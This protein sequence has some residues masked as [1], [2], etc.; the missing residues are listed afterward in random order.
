MPNVEKMSQNQ[1]AASADKLQQ[2]SKDI[3]VDSLSTWTKEDLKDVTL[4]QMAVS[5]PCTKIRA[6]LQYHNVP[7]KIIN[8]KKKDSDYQKVP[9]LVLNGIQLNDSFL[10]VQHLSKIIYGK[11]MTPDEIDFEKQMA[12]GF[13]SACQSNVLAKGWAMRNMV[14]K[15]CGCGAANCFAIFCCTCPCVRNRIQKKKQANDGI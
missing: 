3:S 8:G 4:Y 9:V 12:Y 6:I 5:P 7:F 10:I 1:V 14:G 11:E 13:Q 2:V 15:W